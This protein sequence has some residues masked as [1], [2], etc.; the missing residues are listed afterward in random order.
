MIAEALG[1]AAFKD[2]WWSSSETVPD[3][4]GKYGAHG[5]VAPELQAAVATLSTGPVAVGDP[6]PFEHRTVV[7]CHWW[8]SYPPAH[9]VF[10]CRCSTRGGP[11]CAPGPVRDR[12]EGRGRARGGA[13]R[14]GAR[15]GR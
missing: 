7:G 4:R 1:V 2:V 6:P 8:R 12:R 14:G 13:G 11:P 15:R 9:R 3:A 5:E 10:V